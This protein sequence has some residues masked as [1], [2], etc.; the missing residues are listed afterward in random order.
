MRADERFRSIPGILG[1]VAASDGDRPAIVDGDVRVTF[2][3]LE[4]AMVQ[5]CRAAVAFGIQPGHRVAIWAPNMFEWV[6]AALGALG[7]GAILVPINTRYKS[8]EA[9]QVLDRSGASVLFTVN[10]FL[11]LDFTRMLHDVAPDLP[12]L[13]RCVTLRGEGELTFADFLAGGDA[14]DEDEARARIAAV[15]PT[16]VSD[17]MFTSGT[18]GASKGV[19]LDHGQSLRGFEA[20]NESFG[21]AR[22]DRMAV[23][24]PF[25][26]CFGYKA[27]W[28]LCLMTGAT[29]Y[30]VATF[31]PR[32]L[33]E[34]IEREGISVIAGAPTMMTDVLNVVST[35]SR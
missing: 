13:R 14:V 12:A 22:G 33:V 19:M 24:A 2:A 34:L 16:D 7:A 29:C 15:R 17:I 32:S 18:T 27:G 8:V 1:V 9:T 23:V 11:G 26:H 4:R 30:P 5:S 6:V 10:G 31:D 21:L 28:M 25:F 35:E 20:F 3:E